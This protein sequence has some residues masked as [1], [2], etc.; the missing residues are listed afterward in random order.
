MKLR[1]SFVAN[2]SSTSYFIVNTSDSTRS[3]L[4]FAIQNI[5]LLYEFNIHYDYSFSLKDFL[6]SVTQRNIEF[7]SGESMTL[8]FGDEDGT[9][10][11]HVYDYELRMGGS[12]K[13]WTWRF[14]ESLR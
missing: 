6:D 2:S 9:V 10:V 4:D 12:S 1:M 14:H 8:V 11:G 13:D 7:H 5:E 3:L